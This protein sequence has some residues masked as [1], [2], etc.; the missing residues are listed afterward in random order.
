METENT[1]NIMKN[2]FS[3]WGSVADLTTAAR[4]APAALGTQRWGTVR[5]QRYEV[6]G[7]ETLLSH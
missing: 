5:W 3:R 4:L 7:M 1:S 6:R 2:N